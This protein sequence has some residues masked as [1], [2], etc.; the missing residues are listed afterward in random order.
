MKK[1]LIIFVFLLAFFLSLSHPAEAAA[2]VGSLDAADGTIIA[3]WARDDDYPGPIPV[4]IYV[5]DVLVHDQLANG[6]RSDVGN[7]AFHWNHPPFGVGDHKVVVYAIGVDANGHPNGENPPISG[8]PK[9]F[10]V[11]CARLT[12][13]EAEWCRNNPNYWI[14]RQKDTALVG[15]RY[16]KIGINN[17]YGGMVSQLYSDDRT[18]N[19]IEEHGGAA[20]QLSI[21]GY[22]STST[23]EGWFGTGCSGRCD[24]V[25][26][27]SEQACLE[28][29]NKCVR[30]GHADG[31][32]VSD[33]TR[34]PC[35]CWEVGAPWNPIQAQ[36]AYCTWDSPSNDV[37]YSGR[38]LTGGWEIRLDNPG[39]F[40]KN[41]PGFSGMSFSQKIELE[42]VYAKIDYAI[43][44]NGPY[45]LTSHPQEIPAIFT[46]IG[47]PAKYYYYSGDQPYFD[48]NSPV[49]ILNE[50]IPGF[51]GFPNR[52]TYPHGPPYDLATEGWWG[53]CDATETRCLTVASFS[54]SV[55]EAALHGKE[56]YSYITALGGF[57]IDSGFHREVT[58]YLFPYKYDKVINGKSIRERIFELAEIPPSFSL[59]LGWNQ[60]TWPDVSGKKASDTPLECP[61]A[62]AKEN[63][64]FV[65][66]V[67]N[68]GGV[69]FDFE[70]DKTYYIKCNQEAVWQL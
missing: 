1:I 68:F 41:A 52:G 54:Q 14:N 15:N 22:D 19:L 5:D 30:R 31:A 63:F 29:N 9:Y 23:K 39:H 11:G 7:H 10:N 6:A 18:Y 38:T 21:W 58:I 35:N 27:D 13:V 60:I 2:P 17:S 66:Y 37:D 8:S 55:T 48:P 62:V 70:K 59:S 36:G 51:I 42:D 26:Y 69:N 46:K 45:T 32:H 40:T 24:P 4:H 61:I 25:R 57:A 56:D 67:K 44:Y 47:T 28:H 12:G 64:W 43:D 33:C 49:E 16:V 34:I 20:V 65:P 3:G 53:I 50:P